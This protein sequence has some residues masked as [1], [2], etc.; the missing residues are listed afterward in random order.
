MN[1]LVRNARLVGIISDT[2]GLL[3]PEALDAL[4]GSELI[5]HAGDI[6]SQDV[7]ERL[8]RI[9]P[10]V[11]VRGNVDSAAWANQLPMTATVE[12]GEQRIWVLHELASL[13]VDPVHVGLGSVIYGHSHQ[14]ARYTKDGILYLNPGSAGPRRFRLPVSLVRADFGINPPAINFIDLLSG[15]MFVP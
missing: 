13:D 2:H 12:L 3:R 8:G 4:G 5:V 14:P 1:Q 7:L 9:A 10:V 15:E 11:A 6:G